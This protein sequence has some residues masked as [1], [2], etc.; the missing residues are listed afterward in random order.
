MQLNAG[1]YFCF[2]PSGPYLKSLVFKSSCRLPS[3]NFPR[4]WG[5][6]PDYPSFNTT[7]TV[8]QIL[9]TA[10]LVYGNYFCH[11]LVNI[12]HQVPCV[13]KI[14]TVTDTREFLFPCH[15]QLLLKLNVQFEKRLKFRL[16]CYQHFH[17]PIALPIPLETKLQQPAVTPSHLIFNENVFFSHLCLQEPSMRG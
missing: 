12:L 17:L 9:F 13:I 5:L 7:M 6:M 15:L 1:F 14:D 16:S 2:H 10:S 11:P 3:N 4:K 8:W